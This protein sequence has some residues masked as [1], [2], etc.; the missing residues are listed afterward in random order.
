MQDEYLDDTP[1]ARKDLFRRLI[2]LYAL[3]DVDALRPLVAAD[4]VGHTAAGDRD[5]AEFRQS[6]LNFHQIFEYA[7]DSFIVED[8]FVEGDKV[9]TRMTAHV[10]SRETGEAMTMIGINLAVIRGGQIREEWNTWEMVGSPAKDGEGA[11]DNAS[12]S[13][14]GASTSG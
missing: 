3:G 6:I 5:W 11:A 10:R 12:L 9:A 1:G 13:V 14:R 8:Q 7:P 2:E 4:Y